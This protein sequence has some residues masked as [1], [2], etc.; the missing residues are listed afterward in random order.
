MNL[1]EIFEVAVP[2]KQN[3]L[4]FLKVSLEILLVAAIV[5]NLDF[6]RFVYM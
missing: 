1:S 2:E 4:C 5:F 6:Q 3:L